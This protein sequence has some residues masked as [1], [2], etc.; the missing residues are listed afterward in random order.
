MAERDADA[1]RA[2]LKE[3]QGIELSPE[4][5]GQIAANAERLGRIALEMAMRRQ[6]L[7]DPARFFAVL[8]GAAKRGGR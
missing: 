8:A 7:E 5:A 1:A 6:R 2:F 4:R 3:C